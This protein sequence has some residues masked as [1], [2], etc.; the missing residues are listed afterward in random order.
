MTHPQLGL[1]PYADENA[2]Q[3]QTDIAPLFYW[4]A[5]AGQVMRRVSLADP[6]DR[7]WTSDWVGWS[8]LAA[9]KLIH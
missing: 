1:I 2:D 6:Y 3:G 9:L 4:D 7:H 5:N 8:T